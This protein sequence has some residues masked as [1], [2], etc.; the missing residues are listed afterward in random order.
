MKKETFGIETETRAEGINIFAAYFRQ[1]AD[2]DRYV[3]QTFICL[4][5]QMF[6]RDDF[7]GFRIESFA[8]REKKILPEQTSSQFFLSSESMDNPWLEGTDF[9]VQCYDFVEGLYGM[10]DKGKPVSFGQFND[11]SKSL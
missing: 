1:P 7:H 9:L 8:N 3:R 4:S 5:Q 10:D 11:Y 2:N 6:R